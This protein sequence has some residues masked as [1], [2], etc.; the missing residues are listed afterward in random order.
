MTIR[1]EL[2]F[3]ATVTKVV[4]AA[5][6]LN[7]ADRLA[8]G[9]RSS[10]DLSRQTATDHKSLY[11]LLRTL[12]GLGFVQQS[13]TDEF[14]L[15]EAGESLRSDTDD[16]IHALATML[17][18]KEA[19]VSWGELV[20]A[21]RTGEAGWSQ[22]HGMSWIDFYSRHPEASATFNKAMS[23]HSRDAAPGL[24]EA[25]RPARFDSIVDVGGGDGTLMAELLHVEP[26]LQG[27]VFDLPSGLDDAAA[28]LTARG[29][30]DRCH[31][32][33]GDFF[34]AV[35]ADADAYLL[36]QI[37]HDWDDDAAVQIL[38]SC[39]TAMASDARLLILERMLSEV[40]G[41]EDTPT[42]LIDMHMLVVTGGRER[43]E[44]EFRHL[45]GRAG[46]TM[47]EVSKALPPYGYH[48]IEAAPAQ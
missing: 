14:K 31:L 26:T 46:L 27:I 23:H 21:V 16:S 30:A 20:A 34:D 8:D 10:A 6:E 47:T 12:A 35:P 25:V 18:G 22:A 17:W 4:T 40:V 33:P 39:R 13:D 48:L 41:R 44:A 42:L 43:T 11:R 28:T 32:Q 5:A 15:T 24:V 7:L 36:K 38:T 29:V 9:P 2:L 1:D 3:G 37:L 45:L 19:W